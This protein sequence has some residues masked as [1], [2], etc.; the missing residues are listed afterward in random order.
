M[1]AARSVYFDFY[2]AIKNRSLQNDCW[3]CELSTREKIQRYN[4]VDDVRYTYI[5]YD[6]DFDSVFYKYYLD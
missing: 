5:L 1:D 6:V 3:Q 2:K 4:L